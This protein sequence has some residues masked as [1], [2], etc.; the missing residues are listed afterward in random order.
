[1]Q[2]DAASQDGFRQILGIRFFGGDPQRAKEIGLSGGLV[3]VPAAP[4]LVDLPSDDAYREALLNADLAITDSGFMVL[5][6]NLLKRD[7]LRRVSGLEYLKLILQDPQFKKR[8][9]N[10]WIMPTRQSLERNLRWLRDQGIE[11]SEADCYIAPMYDAQNVRDENLLE[12]LAAHRPAQI[13]IGL[14]GGIQ[15]KLGSYLKD[16]LPYRPGIHCIGAAIAFLSG[17]QVKI[18]EWADRFY[19]GWLLR[20]LSQPRKFFPRYWK[21][22][23][24]LPLMLKY[25]ERAPEPQHA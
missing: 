16:H 8:G 20:S 22:R 21:A 6:W 9:N 5:I 19:L 14:G 18:P 12:L 13:I 2:P 7:R 25:R 10:F 23:K 4:A 24:L 3:V 17:D 1:M 15:E 11:V